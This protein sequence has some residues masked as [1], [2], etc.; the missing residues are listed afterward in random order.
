MQRAKNASRNIVYGTFLKVYQLLGPF[1]LRTIF[2]YTLG[3]EY[4]GLNSL[5]TSI[6][7]VLNLAE[8]GVGA[9]LVFSMYKPIAE[10]DTDK[11]CALMNLYKK[12]YRIIGGIIAI[13]GLCVT[14]FIPKLIAGNLP[15]DVNIYT[16]YLMNLS[17]TV[18]SYWM[19]A[20]KNCLFNAHQ[21]NDVISK[22]TMIIATIQYI[23]QAILLVIFKNYYLYLA[24]TIVAQI[25]TNLYIAYKA[26]KVYK[27]YKAKGELEKNEVKT[28]NR[29]VRDLFTSKIGTIVVDSADTIVISAF[30]GLRILALYN[31]YYY[32]MTT[33]FGFIGIIFVSST[34]GIGN[35]IILESSEKNY[36]DLKK[37]LMII[38]WLAAT[39]TACLLCTYQPF[40]RIWVGDKLMLDYNIVICFC[41]YFFV[42]EINRL[43]NTYKD[44]AGMWHEDRFRPLVTALTNLALNLLLVNYIGLF[45]ILLSTI[46]SMLFVGMPWLFYNLFT[47]IFKRSPWE[48]VMLVIK[49]AL[50][51]LVICSICYYTCY[52]INL[53]G[54][55]DFLVKLIISLIISNLTLIL[56][57]HKTD[58]YGNLKKMAFS[59]VKNKFKKEEKKNE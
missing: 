40:M 51:T 26:N 18:L 10:N 8:L 2:I 54:I 49:Y 25:A 41:V 53:K 50:I 16:L 45:G 55:L 58:E 33:L 21:R 14:P 39:C 59:L 28:I 36:N 44:A 20:Y 48:M 9:A 7:S 12:Y 38:G 43:L 29:R 46:I 56:V 24:I 57:L 17:A 6:L 27:N 47:V 13:A 34:A 15:A 52:F 35:S 31:N 4:L 22:S 23:V 1:I 30:L 32:I 37:M 11:I 19:F 3:V 5:F 42:H